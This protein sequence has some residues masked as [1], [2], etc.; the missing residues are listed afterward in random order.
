MAND[1]YFGSAQ[2]D[3]VKLGSSQVDKVYIGDTLVWPIVSSGKVLTSGL[4]YSGVAS[5]NHAGTYLVPQLTA[6]IAGLGAKFNITV[7]YVSNKNR[8]SV[9]VQAV[10]SNN[11]GSGYAV[12]EII[13]LD[14][15]SVGGSWTAPD[16]EVL[17]VTS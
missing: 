17:T 1:I 14:M 9:T 11:Q 15:S 13:T 6:D 10:D 4:D 3:D 5:G 16:V 2:V 8:S 7:T 12:G